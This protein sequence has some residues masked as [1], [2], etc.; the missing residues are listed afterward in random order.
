MEGTAMTRTTGATADQITAAARDAYNCGLE[1]DDIR[2]DDASAKDQYTTRQSAKWWAGNLV[3][4]DQRIIAVADLK[5]M[6]Y[7]LELFAPDYTPEQQAAIDRITALIGD[8]A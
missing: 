2:F 6:A 1:P 5:A 4:P 8:D 3:R 7:V